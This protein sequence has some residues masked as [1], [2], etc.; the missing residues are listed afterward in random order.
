MV[1]PTIIGYGLM[2]NGIT[3]HP[4]YSIFYLLGL[5]L[6]IYS[7]ISI[8]KNYKSLFNTISPLVFI[9][10]SLLIFA[11]MPPTLSQDVYLY[12]LQGK[13]GIEG[14]LTYT[15]GAKNS[16][17]SF[18]EHVD[19]SWQ[20]CPNHYGPAAMGLF[21]PAA[22]LGGESV[23]SNIISMKIM[24]L[25][26]ALSSGF[27][28]S[29][30]FNNEKE[31]KEKKNQFLLF[32]FLNPVFLIQGIGQMHIDFLLLT[33]CLG[34]IY[35]L[36][37]RKWI[38]AG[39]CVGL[40]GA[41]KFLL[42]VI[43]GG[44]MVIFMVYESLNRKVN[45][46]S[47]IFGLVSIPLTV[48][49]AYF[50]VWENEQTIL[51]PLAFHEDGEPV[52]SVIELL[53]Y[54]VASVKDLPVTNTI[55]EYNEAIIHLKVESSLWLSTV[56][57]FIAL[58]LAVPT[59]IAV[60]NSKTDNEFFV[61]AAKILMIVFLVYSPQMHAWY[62]LLILPFLGFGIEKKYILLYCGITLG[63][64][65]SYEIANILDPTTTTRN[66]IMIVFSIVSVISYYLFVHKFFSP[67]DIKES[68]IAL[69]NRVLNF[70]S[71]AV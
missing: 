42:V 57:G 49:V 58:L 45:V 13:L 67:R 7:Y 35:G 62:F 2:E 71:K 48:A 34:M 68:I 24:Y 64:S 44:I 16:L 29:N 36:K 60:M 59:S 32:T 5:G 39:I 40:M 65:N 38:I 11:L 46:R 70:R 41:T 27:I 56:F 1:I 14:I 31:G 23:L 12:I 21:L 26:I 4:V 55:H 25:L 47:L 9:S 61:G 28:I 37:K 18:V 50:F 53:S 63:L 22:L 43:F 17:H 66:V 6:M 20:D 51:Y 3:V 52:K 69:F 30:L 19:P 54:L 33:F 15:D 8:L 10:I